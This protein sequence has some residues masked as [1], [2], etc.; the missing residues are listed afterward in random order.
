MVVVDKVQEEDRRMLLTK[1]LESISLPDRMTQT[2]SLTTCDA[3]AIFEDLCL[4]GDRERP[5]ETPELF[6][7]DQGVSLPILETFMPVVICHVHSIPSS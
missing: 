5:H 4:L 6:C 7:K 1:E 3:Y 2:L